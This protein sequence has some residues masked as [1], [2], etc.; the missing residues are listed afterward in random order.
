MGEII[1]GKTIAQEFRNALKCAL[2]I[3]KK[4]IALTILQAG[5]N[6]ASNVYVR[7]KQKACEEVGIESKVVKVDTPNELRSQVAMQSD[8]CDAMMI[9]L[10]LPD[11]FGDPQQYIDLIP[12]KKDADCLTTYNLG[13]LFLGDM[14][15]TPCTPTG[16]M[17]LLDIQEIPI[18][19]KHAVVVGRSDIVGKPVAHML[20]ERDAT[21]T[22][23][24]SK[25]ANLADITRMADILIVA[26]GKPNF[27]TADMVKEGAV[28]I[29][30]GINRMED[31]KLCGDV[32]FDNV[33][34]KASAI[35]P[36]PGG[37]G[38]MTVAELL[39]NTISCHVLN[40]EIDITEE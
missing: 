9:Q 22:V 18:K 36:V 40:C 26:I 38:P 39:A 37:V 15:L 19:G 14:S 34:D 32:D 10:P 23:C 8:L 5:D 17:H 11:E 31:G 28:V 6:P 24:H 3:S 4:D 30:V 21:V 35:T 13:R 12:P 25:T 27:I 20:L 33:K 2:E 1:D 16:I 29:D 7:N